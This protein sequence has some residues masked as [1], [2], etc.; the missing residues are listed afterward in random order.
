MPTLN[1]SGTFSWAPSGRGI[2]REGFGCAAEGAGSCGCRCCPASTAEIEAAPIAIRMTFRFIGDSIIE[3]FTT[4]ATERTEY[5]WVPDLLSV[6][7]VISV[8]P[9]RPGS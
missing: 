1:P 4:E 7:S 5:F 9:Q 6:I 2:T 8:V 3:M